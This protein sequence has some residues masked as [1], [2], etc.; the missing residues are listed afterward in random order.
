MPSFFTYHAK[1]INRKLEAILARNL[2]FAIISYCKHFFTNYP[3]KRLIDINENLLI[4][5]K[6]ITIDRTCSLNVPSIEFTKLFEHL[7]FA[8][9]RIEFNFK[10]LEDGGKLY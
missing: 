8:I 5:Y 3:E 4:D 10:I 7:I 2:I 9:N 1:P 6:K